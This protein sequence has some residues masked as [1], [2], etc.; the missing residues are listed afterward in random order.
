MKASTDRPIWI[1]AN[2]GI[3]E[4]IEDEVVYATNAEQ[5][6]TGVGALVEAGANFGRRMLRYLAR[7][8][9]CCKGSHVRMRLL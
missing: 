4:L 5:F 9:S 8:Y 1:K 7:L 3:P 2:A 6:A